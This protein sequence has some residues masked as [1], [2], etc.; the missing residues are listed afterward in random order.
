MR[1]STVEA[2]LEALGTAPLAGTSKNS[3]RKVA[4]LLAEAASASINVEDLNQQL[5]DVVFV[6]GAD[7]TAADLAAYAA[8]HGF[9]SGLA[10]E[11]QLRLCNLTR[12]FDFV[13]HTVPLR[14]ATVGSAPPLVPIELDLVPH[15]GAAS[16]TPEPA[17]ASSSAAAA[18]KKGKGGKGG[19]GWYDPWAGK[20]KGYK[21][22][23][24][25]VWKP[26]GRGRGYRPY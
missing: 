14:R 6:C 17:P 25:P 3:K 15:A 21:G 26:Y 4:S 1:A 11:E 10:R 16:A 13:Q 22:G 19:K 7:I 12:W 23:Y 9:M 18:G 8:L 2:I 5:R 24:G 20:G